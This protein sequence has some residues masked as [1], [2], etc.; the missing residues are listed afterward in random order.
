MMLAKLLTKFVPRRI[1]L[2]MKWKRPFPS[3]AM[4]SSISESSSYPNPKVLIE[5]LNPEYWS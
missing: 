5:Q 1:E 2:G 4:F 3:F